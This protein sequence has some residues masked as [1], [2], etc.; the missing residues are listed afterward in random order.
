MKKKNRSEIRKAVYDVISILGWLF[1]IITAMTVI[2][3]VRDKLINEGNHQGAGII[4]FI[5]ILMV[6]LVILVLSIIQ[7]K[8][9]VTTL[10][11]L[12]LQQYEKNFS[13]NL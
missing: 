3:I 7:T 5:F 4:G 9:D 8:K 13:K 10:F 2:I 1:T 12:I 6:L 11:N